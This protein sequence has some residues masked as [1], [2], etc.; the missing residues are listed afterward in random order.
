MAYWLGGTEQQREQADVALKECVT[1]AGEKQIAKLMLAGVRVGGSPYWLTPYRWGY[2]WPYW[3]GWL[4][5]GYKVLSEEEQVQ[6]DMELQRVNA[7]AVS[8]NDSGIVSGAVFGFVSPCFNTLVR[9]AIESA[10]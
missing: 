2:G 8:G 7:S 10:M 1:A 5:R 6:A 4:P 9:L 3:D